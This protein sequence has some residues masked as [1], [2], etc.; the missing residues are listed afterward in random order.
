MVIAQK[1]L[2]ALHQDYTRR[3]LE[4][5]EEERSHVAREVHDDAIQRLVVVRHELDQLGSP[6]RGLDQASLHHLNGIR[7]EVQDL[8]EALRRLAHR[9]H[10]TAIEKAGISVALGQ[11]ADEMARSS[12]LHVDLSLPDAPIRLPRDVS[13]AIF[14]IAQESLRNVVRHAGVNEASL[15]LQENAGIAELV[16]RDEGA[17]FD[18]GNASRAGIGLVGIEERVRLVGGSARIDSVPG[19]GTTVTV[20][21]PITKAA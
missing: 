4:A 5:H 20:R 9:L 17:G 11:L 1:R 8:A 21:I 2:V 10:P 16:I 7:N 6:G 18:R 12:N 19:E 3:L 13:L 14:R 15:A